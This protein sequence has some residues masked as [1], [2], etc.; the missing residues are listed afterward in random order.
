MTT[1]KSVEKKVVGAIS[2][3]AKSKT[4]KKVIKAIDKVAKSQEVKKALTAVDK[5]MKSP[6]AKKL[7]KD[8]KCCCDDCADD[9]K[10][11]GQDLMARIKEM[12]DKY[13]HMDDKTK[14]QIMT[15]ITGAAAFLAGVAIAAGGKKKKNKK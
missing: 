11:L 15:G 6:A 7:Q 8:F 4:T 14:K 13:E 1:K 12:K 10:K 9:A 3:A 2:N 5:A